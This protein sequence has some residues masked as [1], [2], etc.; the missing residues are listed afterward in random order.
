LPHV[1]AG[2]VTEKSGRGYHFARI[3][4]ELGWKSLPKRA[5]SA[6]CAQAHVPGGVSG[7][8]DSSDNAVGRSQKRPAHQGLQFVLLVSV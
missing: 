8:V 7:D 4:T 3:A 6:L 5:A 2:I 1:L